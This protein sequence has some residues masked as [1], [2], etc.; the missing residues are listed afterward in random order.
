MSADSFLDVGGT[1]LPLNYYRFGTSD[2]YIYAH[3]STNNVTIKIGP[4][5]WA[6]NYAYFVIEYTKT[7]D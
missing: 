3:A 1:T 6:N 5:G 2:N 4:S 7:T